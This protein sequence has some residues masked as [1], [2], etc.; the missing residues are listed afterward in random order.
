MSQA[1]PAADTPAQEEALC[2]RLEHVIAEESPGSAVEL[3]IQSLDSADDPRMLLEALL[4]KARLELNLP[5]V[6]ATSLA[7]FPEPARSAYE[8]KYV[9]AIKSVGSKLLARGEIAAA[10]PYFRAIG[11][12]APVVAA[13][14]SFTH[15]P[16]A[17]GDDV[18][19]GVIDVAFNQG[20]HPSRGFAL[21]LENYGVCSAITAFEQL[22]H[23]EPSR[24]ECAAKL[25]RKLHEDLTLNL[26]ADIERNG[27][28]K[29]SDAGSTIAELI[30]DRS[31]LFAEE[32]YHSDVSHLAAAV[33][34][35]LLLTDPA[36]LRLALDL[37]EYGKRLGPRHHYEGLAPFE[38]VYADH[39]M[40]IKAMLGVEVDRAIEH[41]DLKVR[42]ARAAASERGYPAAT[43]SLP[44]QVLVLLLH[45]VGRFD[46]AIDVFAEQL[47]DAPDGALICPNLIKLCTS[48]GRIDRL[49]DI[50]RRRGDPVNFLAAKL[51]IGR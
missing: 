22:P 30:R 33:R 43:D 31:W 14:E 1:P 39:A 6:P 12:K 40:F 44:A 9:D 21:I 28:Q 11:E 50:S 20:V 41:F 32:A 26:R 35:S 19:G 5:L 23:D 46:R 16:Q 48:A 49:I 47:A 29:P 42:Q 4:L 51:A 17:P 18:L 2:D 24:L 3:L 7:E 13:I 34:A 15:D 8:E 25:I 45:R 37:C 38:N 36:S 27:K 10:W